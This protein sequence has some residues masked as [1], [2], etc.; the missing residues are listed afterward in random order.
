MKTLPKLFV[1]GLITSLFSSCGVLRNTTVPSEG[2]LIN[3]TIWARYNVDAPGTFTANIE[4]AGM[5]YQW[6]KNVGWS[7]TNPLT[8]Y[9]GST[10]WDSSRSDAS[11]WEAQNNPCPPGWRVPAPIELWLL[12]DAGSVWTTVNGVVGRQFGSGRNTIFLPAPGFR[13]GGGGLRSVDVFGGYWSNAYVP[14]TTFAYNLSFR[15]HI[16]GPGTD[17]SRVVG[18]N[19]R[20]VFGD[21]R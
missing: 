19:V 10:R 13:D 17:N 7:T 4:D 18:F 5:F 1:I 21:R 15:P 16:A 14:G 12:V 3:G 9:N 8:A 11:H 20:C 2:V 6:N